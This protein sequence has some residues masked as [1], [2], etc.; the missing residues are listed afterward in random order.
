MGCPFRFLYTAIVSIILIGVYEKIK[1]ILDSSKL[2][3]S[4]CEKIKLI[5]SVLLGKSNESEKNK[6][7]NHLMSS[8][9]KA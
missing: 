4:F 2:E 8:G 9:S 5:G 7:K 3:M 1:T 6:M